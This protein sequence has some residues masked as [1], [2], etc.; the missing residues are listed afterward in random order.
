MTKK[1]ILPANLTAVGLIALVASLA[2]AES[3]SDS[4]PTGQLEL[5]L[6]P[7]MTEEQ[8]QACVLAGTPG[9]MH[10]RLAQDVG[11]WHG[12]TTM[13]M[14]PDAEPTESEC[15]STVTSIMDG[16]YIKGE[17][18]GEMPGMGAY[19]GFGIS[20]FDNVSQ[21]FVSTWIDNHSTGIMQGEGQLSSD[22]KTLTWTFT[23]NCPITK[24]PTVM[25]E[26]D[27]IT[28]PNSKRLEMFGTD[29]TSGKEFKTMSIELTKK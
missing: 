6:P 28:G 4:K 7:G 12:K 2:T 11:E 25:R 19:H 17:M 18:E 26:V 15:T 8:M 1:L 5:Q 3:S 21:K 13:W 20:G 16:R 10:K 9:E 22:G 24:K 29:L 27:T 14:T 23:Y